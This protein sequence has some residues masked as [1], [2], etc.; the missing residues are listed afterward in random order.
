M[1][2]IIGY[3][4]HRQAS[5]VL[6]HGLSQVEYRGYDSA[7]MAVSD[8]K[9]LRILKDQGKLRDI[10]AKRNFL[11]LEG[12]IGLG[13][14]RWAT[15]GPPCERNAHPHYDCSKKVAVVHNGI[16]E[17]HRALKAELEKKGHKF[18]SDTDTEI[19]AHLIEE[20]L[21][22]KKAVDLAVRSALSRLEGTYALGI[23]IAGESRL[24]LA[25]R[26]APLIVGKGKSDEMFFASDIP[27]LLGYTRDFIL[28]N[29]GDMAQIDSKGV[30][31]WG[32]DGKEASRPPLHVDWTP[33]MAQKMGHDF[34]MLKEILE[35]PV[36]LASALSADVSE[37]VKLLSGAKRPAIVA[38]GT[39]YYAAL[40]MQYLLHKQKREAGAYLGSE[41]ASWHTGQ[42][43]VVVAISQSGETADTLSAIRLAKKEGAAVLAITNVVGSTLSREADATLYIGVGPEVGVVATKT[44]TGQLAIIYKLAYSLSGDKKGM[45]A[46]LQ[47]P[48]TVQKMLD[49]I[50][51]AVR[52]LAKLMSKRRNFFFISRGVGWPC[53]L[54]A[55]LKLKEI[56]YL[57]AEAYAAGEL[58]HGPISML[59]DKVPVIAIAPSGA[60]AAKME[61]NIRECK[62][63]GASL[64][65]LSDDET[66]RKEGEHALVMPKVSEDLV[67]L[68]YILPLQLLAY[69][70]TIELGRD[71]DQPRNLAKSVTVE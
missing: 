35:Q 44:F 69:Y 47:S 39:S 55:A 49:S 53:A 17:N 48:A 37:G 58:K 66:I 41:Y 1:C 26:H 6:L 7:G 27:A 52:E 56:T 5:E 21:K 36:T 67:P 63:R 46:L 24:F 18:T 40:V 50:R 38:C 23:L 42:E 15:H 11:Q 2:G 14:T 25:R 65:V 60:L 3:I 70:M 71:P 61:S 33:Q 68:F 13:H 59:E 29:E 8:G 19:A 64:V 34:F 12:G 28:L 16:I 51:P 32:A 22:Q 20:E 31:I 62:A 43:D 45:D 9:A 54:E 57:H 4:G 10:H 30:K